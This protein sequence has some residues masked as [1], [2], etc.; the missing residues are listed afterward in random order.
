MTMTILLSSVGHK[1]KQ[2]IEVILTTFRI[3]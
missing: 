1:E 3:L 2:L